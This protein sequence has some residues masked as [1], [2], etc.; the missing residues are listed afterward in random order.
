MN[1]RSRER[2]GRAGRRRRQLSGVCAA[3]R[4]QRAGSDSTQ[5]AGPQDGSSPRG[6]DTSR[7]FRALPEVGKKE[8]ELLEVDVLKE[9]DDPLDERVYRQLRDSLRG[10]QGGKC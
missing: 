1:C 4:L 6:D 10:T 9:L 7:V 5:R 3:G 2:E 8:A